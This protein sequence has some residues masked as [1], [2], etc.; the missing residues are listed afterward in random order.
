MGEK[1]KKL[2]MPLSKHFAF[3]FVIIL[4]ISCLIAGS[5]VC[6]A[7]LL[8]YQGEIT[9]KIVMIMCLLV[10]LLVTLIGSGMMWI[11][12]KHLVTPIIKLRDGLAQV[13]NG[14][15]KVSILR[16][17]K[18]RGNYD[19]TNELDEVTEYFNRMARELNH[20]DYMRKDFMSNVSHEVKTPVAAITGFT[21]ILLDGGLSEEEQKEYL[22]M[23]NEQSIRLSNLC[24]NMLRLSKLDS[25]EI[26]PQ[27]DMVQVDE[28]IR[29]T[30]ILLAEKWQD[31]SMDFILDLEKN[32]FQSNSDLL[33]QVWMN[34]IDNAIKYSDKGKRIWIKEYEIEG[35]ICVEIEDEGI[36]IEEEKQER[37]FDK[38]YQCDESHKKQGNGLGL[39]IVKRIVL[40]LSG[41]IEYHS[42]INKGSKFIVKIPRDHNHIEH[43]ALKN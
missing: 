21:E 8:F 4:C 14:D 34:I 32:T 10:C 12:I 16:N 5:L 3:I 20:M 24:G 40:M 13:T 41:S 19:Y 6:A 23:V 17:A 7:F 15:F 30:V 43:N 25:Q 33:S 26:V 31:R 29:K 36:G 22:T 38:F 39:S 28:Q 1:N 35:Y 18:N 42:S 9:V 37:I 27:N 2:R 11:G